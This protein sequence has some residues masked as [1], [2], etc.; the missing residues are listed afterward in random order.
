V[1]ITLYP[2]Y[3][4]T[5]EDC[6]RQY[7]Y[8]YIDKIKTDSTSANLIFGSTIHKVIESY[9]RAFELRLPYDIEEGFKQLWSEALTKE[10]IQYN[11]RWDEESLNETGIS[12]VKEFADKWPDLNLSPL[13]DGD[14]ELLLE[15]KL[16]TEIA[17]GIF[18]AAKLD[19]A[20]MDENAEVVIIDF[21]SPSNETD[22]DHTDLDAQITTQQIVTDGNK[23]MLGIDQVDKVGFLELVK[24]KIPK[25]SGKGPTVEKPLLVPRRNDFEIAEFKQK[26]IW[27]AG[28]IQRGE[29][30]KHSRQAY[31]S[32][33]GM[34]DYANY[35]RKG[36]REG[37]VF[38]DHY[39]ENAA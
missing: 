15:R 2:T 37:L 6:P 23:D 34:C 16:K 39:K 35:C 22:P 36:D 25:R 3:I 24:R 7:R 1:A 17:P 18:L 19:I 14:E 28:A 21:K 31:N 5:F 26:I 11:S 12:L 20:A 4:A 10:E 13:I 29:F 38:P 32:P 33:C 8:K 27:M 9:I 30:P